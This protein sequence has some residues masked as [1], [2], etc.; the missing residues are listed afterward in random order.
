MAQLSSINSILPM[1]IDG[2]GSPDLVIGGNLYTFLPQFGR[3]DASFGEL[4]IE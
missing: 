2:N 1:D 4:V 3:L